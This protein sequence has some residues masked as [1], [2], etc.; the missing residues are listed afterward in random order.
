[1]SLLL[2]DKRVR[3]ALALAVLEWLVVGGLV[4]RFGGD[5]LLA[6]GIVLVVATWL[7]MGILFGGRGTRG[8]LRQAQAAFRQGNYA[9]A[10]QLLEGTADNVPGQTLLGNTYRQQ[11]RLAESEATLRAAVQRAPQDAFPLYGLGR[12]LLAQ[13]NYAEA[14]EYINRALDHGGRQAI[15]CELALAHYLNNTPDAALV[16]AQKTS[17]AL[18]L[19]P[20]RILMVNYLL[21][22]LADD[23]RAPVIIARTQTGLG[24]WRAEAER[25]ANT[26]YGGGLVSEIGILEKLIHEELPAS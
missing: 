3:A 22:R 9:Q 15:R 4:V 21:Y 12:T 14:A 11:N 6:A 26:P 10:A 19:E 18:G 20:Y 17:R 7:Q 2:K 23:A 25:F 1:M 5:Q 13:G 8:P 24:Y 16:A